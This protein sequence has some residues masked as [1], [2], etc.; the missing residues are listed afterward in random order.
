MVV[1]GGS[2]LLWLAWDIPVIA[3]INLV[4]GLLISQTQHQVQPTAAMKFTEDR[5]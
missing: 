3:A 1:G 4:V 5:R 2:L